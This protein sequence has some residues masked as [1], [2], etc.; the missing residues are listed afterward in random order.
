MTNKELIAKNKEY[1]EGFKNLPRETQAER[2]HQLACRVIHEAM[3]D[4]VGES[5]PSDKQGLPKYFFNKSVIL[6]DL[7]TQVIMVHSNGANEM[8]ITALKNNPKK[9]KQ[10]IHKMSYGCEIRKAV[11]YGTPE[12]R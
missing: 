12:F 6:N 3:A 8:A 5:T 9:V 10:N 11:R 7:K 1:S 4:Y 2:I